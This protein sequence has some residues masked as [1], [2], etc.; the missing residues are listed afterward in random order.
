MSGPARPSAMPSFAWPTP[1]PALL[2]RVVEVDS[3]KIELNLCKCKDGGCARLDAGAAKIETRCLDG[4]HDK[5]CGNESAFYPPLSKGVT[6]APAVATQHSF[7]G[8]AFNAT[9][10]DSERRGAYVGSFEAH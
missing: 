4:H 5:V 8:K 10:D 9:W 3:A 7:S 2:D 1:R 6:A